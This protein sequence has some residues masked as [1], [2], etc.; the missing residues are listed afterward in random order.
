[1]QFLHVALNYSSCIQT[2]PFFFLI[3]ERI[4]KEYFLIHHC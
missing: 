4:L 3:P 2:L 1:M